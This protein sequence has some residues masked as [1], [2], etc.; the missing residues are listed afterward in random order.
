LRLLG[1]QQAQ[2]MNRDGESAVNHAS[3]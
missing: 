3:I 2:N 1:S